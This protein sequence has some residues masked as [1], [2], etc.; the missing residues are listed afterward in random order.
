MFNCEKCNICMHESVCGRKDEYRAA[1]AAVEKTSYS[2]GDCVAVVKDTPFLC[3]KVECR[4][5]KPGT[6]M[7]H[8][9]LER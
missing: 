3:V 1:C 2:H 7:R 4:Y 9:G 5:F 6:Q 8:G